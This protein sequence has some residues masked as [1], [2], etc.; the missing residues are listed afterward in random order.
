MGF[1]ALLLLRRCTYPPM[2]KFPVGGWRWRNR[3]LSVS[4]RSLVA[5]RLAAFGMG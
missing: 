1:V 3:L 2:P 4:F 5:C